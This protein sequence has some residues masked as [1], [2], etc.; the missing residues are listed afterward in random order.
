LKKVK[1][2]CLIQKRTG[3][4]LYCKFLQ[5]WRRNSRSQDWPIFCLCKK[6]PKLVQIKKR[7]ILI[8][9]VKYL[10]TTNKNL[11][12]MLFYHILVLNVN[13]LGDS[14]GEHFG[15]FSSLFLSYHPIPYT[16]Y[17]GGIRSL[18]PYLQSPR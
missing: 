16:L 14:L 7:L 4:L 5:S 3:Y 13:S 18:D 2:I 9:F 15:C 12:K 6:F 8:I 10:L 11:S 17:P 1:N